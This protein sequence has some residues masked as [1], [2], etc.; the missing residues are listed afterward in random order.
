MSLFTGEYSPTELGYQ[1]D[2]SE[3]GNASIQKPVNEHVAVELKAPMV[4]VIGEPMKLQ[5]EGQSIRITNEDIEA[6]FLPASVPL[7]FLAGYLI[8]E[9]KGDP[10]AVSTIPLTAV[11]VTFALAHNPP[12][13]L[14]NAVDRFEK[15]TGYSDTNKKV[16]RLR[17]ISSQ[18]GS[19]LKK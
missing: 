11:G 10:V 6:A 7:L 15:Y 8:G 17:K 14:V 13:W 4:G 5:P 2:L 12:K 18:K 3:R 19:F 16:A 1:P 9:S